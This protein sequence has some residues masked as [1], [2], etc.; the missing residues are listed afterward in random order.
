LEFLGNGTVLAAGEVER[1]GGS[2]AGVIHPAR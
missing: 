1:R 2:A